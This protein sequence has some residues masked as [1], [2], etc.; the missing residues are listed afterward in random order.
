MRSPEEIAHTLVRDMGDV[1]HPLAAASL[2]RLIAAALR[3]ER[4]EVERLRAVA[5]RHRALVAAIEDGVPS[6]LWPHAVEASMF[7]SLDAGDDKEPA[8]A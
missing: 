7:A 6:G 1:V 5:E 4:A 8:D 3:V 2:E